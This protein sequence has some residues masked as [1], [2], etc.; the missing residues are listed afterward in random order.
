MRTLIVAASCV[1]ALAQPLA[2]MAQNAP[3][4]DHDASILPVVAAWA[5][6]WNTADASAMAALFAPDGVYEDWAFQAEFQGPEGAALWVELTAAAIPD[7]RMEVLDAF[8]AGDRIA[9]RWTFTGTPIRFA[10]IPSTGESFSVPV[11]SVIE[12][13]DGRIA[14]V[15]DAYNLADLFRQVGVDPSLW[16]PPVP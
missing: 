3:P 13:E 10:D 11:V 6:A 5:E 1:L 7:A 8:Q 15:Q 12:L 14:R 16:V 4:A 2:V 9:V